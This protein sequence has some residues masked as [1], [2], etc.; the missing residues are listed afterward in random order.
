MSVYENPLVERYASPEM[1]LLFSAETKFRMWRKLWIALAEA[2][3]EL[4]FQQIPITEEQLEELRKFQDHLNLEVARDYERKLKHDVMAHIHAYSDQ[5]PKARSILHLGA[6]SAY[7]S[8][9]TDLILI[10]EG[11]KLIQRRLRGVIKTLAEFARTYHQLPTLAFTHFQP[12]QLTTVGKRACLWLQDLKMDW[13]ALAYFLEHLQFLGVKGTTG[14]QA[15]FLYLFSGDAEKVDQLD[16]KVAKKMG[17]ERSFLISGQT[18]PRKVDVHVLQVLAG[19][20]QSAHKFAED[21]RLLCHLQEIEEP[22]EAEQVG[23]SAMAFKQNPIRSER[24]CALAR[25]VMTL[26]QNGFFTAATQWF[27]RTLDDSANRRLTVPQAFLAVDAILLLY[28]YIL[29]GIRVHQEKIQQH[30]ERELPFM[31]T[32]LVLMEACK[33]GG[34]RQILHERI[35]QLSFLV[36]DEVQ[37]GQPNDLLSRLKNDPLFHG[38]PLETLMSASSIYGRAPEQVCIFLKEAIDPLFSGEAPTEEIMLRV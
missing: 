38:V 25:F 4:S 7:V 32:E 23:S 16:Q 2:Q 21:L 33:R 36:R 37:K 8:D 24:I 1:C 17:F 18:Y 3:K 31:A 12:A 11:M 13:D 9:N 20:A 30:V 28:H 26:V 35:R 10:R 14:T 19:I 5:C 27:E 6:T 29:K 15:S 22:M 34:D